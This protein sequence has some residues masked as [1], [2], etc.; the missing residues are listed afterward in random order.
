[1]V[2]SL[3]KRH[4]NPEHELKSTLSIPWVYEF[5]Q[6]SV[7]AINLRDR[8]TREFL[9]V[10]PGERVL[11]IGCGPG[12]ILQA[13][14]EDVHYVGIDLSPSYIAKAKAK[15][16][17]RGTFLCCAVD[18]VNPDELGGKFD[19]AMANG[20]VHHLNDDEARALYGLA[21]TKLSTTGRF[22]SFDGCFTDQQHFFARW[23]LKNDRGR[24]VRKQAGYEALAGT[25]FTS[26]K[27]TVVHDLLRIPYTHIILDCRNPHETSK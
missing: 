23:M 12:D 18:A 5:F 20:V 4:W 6:R 8:Y 24:F 26:V 19:L 16:G 9:R 10:Q 13:L 7:G 21:A 22:C 14:P 11:D 15:Y 3:D 17:S 2:T 25:A 27:S 1:M